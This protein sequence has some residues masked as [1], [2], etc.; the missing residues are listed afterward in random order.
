MCG[1][2]GQVIFGNQKLTDKEKFISLLSL[3]SKRGPD[4]QGYYSNKKNIQFG[5]NRLSILDLSENASQPIKSPSGR[6][7]MVFNGEIYNH[8]ELRNSLPKKKFTFKGSG[9][10]ESV[11]SCF[12]NFGI[13]KTI[14][15]LDGM[16]A[17]GIYDN[18]NSSLYLIR[19]FAGIKP[20]FYGFKNRN[21][22]FAS[23]YNQI[24]RHEKFNFESIDESVLKLYLSFNYIPSPFGI[25]KNTYSINPGE[26]L[27]FDKN[28]K[29]FS[30]T[31]WDFPEYSNDCIIS[32]SE[33]DYVEE[34]IESAVKAQLISDV[35][36]GSFLSG[37]V[38]SPLVSY[39]A[40]KNSSGDFNTYCMGS[41]SYKH[42]ESLAA[43]KFAESLGTIHHNCYMNSKNSLEALEKSIL[44]A[45]EPFGDFSIIPTWQISK[46]AKEK[47]KV[48]LSGDGGDELFFGYERFK[49]V[50]KNYKLWGKPYFKRF[51]IRYTDKIIFNDK[52]FNDG[53]LFP[54][55]GVSLR[56]LHFRMPENLLNK[57]IPDLSTVNLPH[58]F[59]LYESKHY[60]SQ[61]E[62]LYHLRK[63]EFYGMMQKTLTKLDR[64]SMDH[65]LEARV[66]FLQKKLIENILKINIQVHQPMASRK[67]ILFN[68]LN[69]LYP[70]IPKQ[71]IKMGFSV[72]LTNWLKNDYNKPFRE[73]LLDKNFQ[74]S[75]GIDDNIITKM[76]EKHQSG[77]IDN[78]WSLFSLYS[79]ALWF[80][81][82]SQN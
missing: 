68:L 49:S 51:L 71:N 52:H 50:A 7:I 60:S 79:L 59:T 23:Q 32:D 81:N 26:I 1:I 19:D 65:G 13:E 45:G 34:H 70:S 5:F 16:F 82:E 54:S 74:H 55:A 6:Y 40:K 25:L 21:I 24:S 4:F 29:R 17:I 44:A 27:R 41:D 69:K 53:A 80:N 78:K 31:Y 43:S 57:L 14:S 20:L 61:N 67:K 75:F 66:P 56:G 30:K 12:E 18:Y 8:L 9:D 77:L 76:L 73:K 28:G 46:M 36:L 38:D 48:I 11:I 37:G 10:T 63:M 47:V 15:M 22:I 39:F 33:I 2:Y 58:D 35:P 64:A 72:S 3:S 62:L 42:D